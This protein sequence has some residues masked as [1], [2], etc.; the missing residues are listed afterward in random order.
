MKRSKKELSALK[1]A[2]NVILEMKNNC[3][4]VIAGA[5][6]E[7]DIESDIAMYNRC[8]EYELWYLSTQKH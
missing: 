8:E 3:G 7:D 2:Y 4:N 6:K 1:S 5:D